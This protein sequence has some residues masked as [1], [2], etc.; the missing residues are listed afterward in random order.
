LTPEELVK[1]NDSYMLTRMD[2]NYISKNDWKHFFTFTFLWSQDELKNPQPNANVSLPSP[3]QLVIDILPIYSQQ[4]YNAWNTVV[5]SLFF[6]FFSVPQGQLEQQRPNSRKTDFSLTPDEMVIIR[7]L[8]RM[9][10][11]EDD[12]YYSKFLYAKYIFL[13]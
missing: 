13:S 11:K 10:I 3:D 5:Y 8:S 1:K 9:N 6:F 4:Y 2:Q 12:L 7:H